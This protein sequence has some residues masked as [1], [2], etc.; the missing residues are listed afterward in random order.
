MRAAAV[1]PEVPAQ[2]LP[3]VGLA[4]KAESMRH[5]ADDGVRKSVEANGPA[6]DRR[7]AAE[8]RLP[9]S[10]ADDR[11]LLGSEEVRMHREA[12]AHGRLH[13]EHVEQV[14]GGLNRG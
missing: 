9:E 1:I 11:F 5:D 7:V 13:A 10:M 4:G 2:L 8:A 6:D 3:E 14:V 12:T